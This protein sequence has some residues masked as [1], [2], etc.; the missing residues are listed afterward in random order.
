MSR[1]KKECLF[2]T[3]SVTMTVTDGAIAGLNAKGESV[4]LSAAPAQVHL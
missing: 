1:L 4:A 2:P 3:G